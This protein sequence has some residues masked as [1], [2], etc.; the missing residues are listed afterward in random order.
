MAS[1]TREDG[2][3][4]AYDSAEGVEA[5]EWQRSIVDEG[6]SPPNVAIDAQY[7]A[8][9][10]GETSIT[11]D[12]IWQINDL[13]ADR[14]PVRHRARSRRSSTSRPQWANSHHF[15]ISRAGAADDENKQPPRRCSSPG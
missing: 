1:R 14:G 9:K 11:W 5:L 4:A 3:E 8:F 7:V 10:N 15:F 12:G 2:S 13:E 6:Y